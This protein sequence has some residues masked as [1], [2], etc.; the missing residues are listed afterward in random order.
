MKK[1]LIIIVTFL[2]L[3]SCTPKTDL[4]P[5]V[6]ED[7]SP[8]SKASTNPVTESTTSVPETRVE[9]T[10]AP[11]QVILPVAIHMISRDDDYNFIII[12]MNG[13][14]VLDQ[15]FTY[16][17]YLPGTS[18]ASMTTDDAYVLIDLRDLSLFPAQDK[19]TLD[20]IIADQVYQS[21]LVPFM[22]TE[23]NLYGY[24]KDDQVL[25]PPTYRSAGHFIDGY[26]VVFEGLPY[27]GEAS[28]I[29]QNFM[30]LYSNP[31]SILSFGHGFFGQVY[32]FDFG[33]YSNWYNKF[34]L[35]D[36]QGHAITEDLLFEARVISEDTLLV[37][38]HVNRWYIDSKGNKLSTESSDL[39][40]LPLSDAVYWTGDYYLSVGDP[41]NYDGL[42]LFDA[43]GHLLY[44]TRSNNLPV[45]DPLSD[46]ISLTHQI[47]I[48]EKFTTITIPQISS[49]LQPK[50]FD[51]F[52]QQMMTDY[53]DHYEP[54]T[55]D[56]V[57]NET[58]T[59]FDAEVHGHILDLTFSYYWYGFGAAHP[60]HAQST[61]HLDLTNGLTYTAGDLSLTKE[62]F[63]THITDMVRAQAQA[64]DPEAYWDIAEI[65]VDEN[66][67]YRHAPDGLI[68]YY[69][70]Y[71]ISAYAY[72]YPEF[73][74]PYEDLEGFLNVDGD[75]YQKLMAE[76]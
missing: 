52:N 36:A 27:D 54:V 9:V 39:E 34:I 3:S 22:D 67:Q 64:T 1:T 65:V 10:T 63:Y 43:E 2:L 31:L 41:Y 30:P 35:I 57:S 47:V 24:K 25:V 21:D 13:D 14:P 71:E 60:N 61:I 19:N 62:N 17:E 53:V 46:D 44:S 55:V 42:G 15:T 29:D 20:V 38:D 32:D 56:M 49:T 37:G 5:L 72:G 69:S 40:N 12:D 74:I 6:E 48:Q 59:S 18:Y 70:P 26:A 68:F 28:I 11:P 76:E 75:Y 51:T 7:P 8:M 50:L 23:T 45:I 66:T 33:V 4:P 16:G 73:L 58:E